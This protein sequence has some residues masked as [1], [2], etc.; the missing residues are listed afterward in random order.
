MIHP[1][2][3][4]RRSARLRD[5]RGQRPYSE[6]N[7]AVPFSGRIL[8]SHALEDWKAIHSLFEDLSET[9]LYS[10]TTIL[11]Q[12]DTEVSRTGI[13]DAEN[14]AQKDRLDRVEGDSH[15][16]RREYCQLAST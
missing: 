1:R 9:S 3:L 2:V 13:V 12:L 5:H 7:T 16:W 4:R 6:D 10:M 8:L 15:D 14:A 11:C